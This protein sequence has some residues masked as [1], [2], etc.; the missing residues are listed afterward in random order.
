VGEIH[1]ELSLLTAEHGLIRA[2][3]HGLRG[4][5]SSLRPKCQTYSLINAYLFEDTQKQRF[6]LSDAEVIADY[7]V[8]RENLGALYHAAAMAEIL[9]RTPL[10]SGDS[11]ALSLCLLSLEGLCAARTD[12]A[13]PQVS[14]QFLWRYLG[15]TGYQPDPTRCQATGTM[16]EPDEAVR[17]RS[18]LGGFVA[19]HADA[20]AQP[21]YRDQ[22]IQSLIPAGALAYLRHSVR[23]DFAAACRVGLSPE[24][25]NAL[26][27][28]LFRLVEDLLGSQLS[29]LQGQER[30][31]FS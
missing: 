6:K 31:F 28:L 1:A 9:K 27:R 18:S 30:L 29:S 11:W 24:A 16:L 26:L 8:L 13:I 19:V 5:K 21:G 10:E 4:Q 12:T 2:N 14:L 17:Y 20:V 22:E 23:M 7:F 25:R 15:F 3:A